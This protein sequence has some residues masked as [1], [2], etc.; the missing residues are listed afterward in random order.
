MSLVIYRRSLPQS[1]KLML[2]RTKKWNAAMQREM[3]KENQIWELVEL[4]EGRRAVGI[5]WVYK[6]NT[7]SDGSIECYKAQ[8]VAKEFSQKFGTDYD[9]TFCPVVRLESFRTLVA[10]SVQNGLTLHQVDVTTAFLNGELEEEVYMSQPHGFVATDQ[11]NLVCKLKKSIYGLKQS[12]RCWNLTLHNHL[13]KMGFLQTG[14]DPCIYRS[15]R[16][17]T[18][19]IGVYVDDIVLA[20]KS[21]RMMRKVKKA[22]GEKFDI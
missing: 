16:G 2:V 19:L 12:P 22:L 10:L 1:K 18:F 3:L 6:L 15:S 20:G 14:S 5:K 7:C 13:K 17:E 9:E 4:P 8:L 21:E 11:Q